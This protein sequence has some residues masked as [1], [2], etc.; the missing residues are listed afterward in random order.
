MTP[1][2]QLVTR[3]EAPPDF[4]RQCL[5]EWPASHALLRAIE[6]RKLW[7][8]PLTPPV[9]DIGCGDGIF[10]HLLFSEPLEAGIDLN[11]GEIRRAECKGSHRRLLVGSGTHLPF[12]DGT[13]RSVF[14]NCVLEHIDGLD[15]ALAEISRVLQPGGMLLTTVP[16]PRWESE[17]PFPFLRRWGW[18]GLSERLN[19]VLRRVWHHVTVEDEEA[20]R[21]RLGR[22]KMKMINW[23]PYMVP[24]AYSAYAGFLPWSFGS[25]ISR[26][27]TGRWFLCK[28]LRRLFVPIL[29]RW[30]RRAYLAEDTNGACALLVAVKHD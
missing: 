14:S 25:F 8:Y 21:T 17:G 11:P 9:L 29:S 22:A 23:E 28:P 18:H 15:L 27:L 16:T 10:T 12:A 7:R 20:W 1:S 3:M 13:F 30:L 26:R 2:N 5:G 6:L 4:L 24:I 19:T